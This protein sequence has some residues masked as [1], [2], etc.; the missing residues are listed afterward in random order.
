M[1]QYLKTRFCLPRQKRV[2]A[3]FRPQYGKTRQNKENS[4]PRSALAANQGPFF[5]LFEQ[6]IHTTFSLAA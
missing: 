5:T 4:G 3:I 2:F 1:L 6:K